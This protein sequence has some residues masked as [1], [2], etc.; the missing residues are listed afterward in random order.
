MILKVKFDSVK[1]INPNHAITIIN[2]MYDVPEHLRPYGKPLH[3]AITWKNN[4]AKLYLNGLLQHT[5]VSAE[6]DTLIHYESIDVS[7]LYIG[8]WFGNN[9][10]YFK[11][12]T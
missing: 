5:E 12:I 10:R 7:K 9:E 11:V 3:V 8:N 6:S 1:V 4:T 2:L